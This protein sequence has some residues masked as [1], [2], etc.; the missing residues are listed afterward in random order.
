[1]TYLF[2]CY[3]L[4]MILVVNSQF[5]IFIV[6]LDNTLYVYLYNKYTICICSSLKKYIYNTID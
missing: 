2:F 6:H 5:I 4:C 1:M 3:L